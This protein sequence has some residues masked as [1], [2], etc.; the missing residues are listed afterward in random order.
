MDE[1][2]RGEVA[3]WLTKARRDL[4]SAYRLVAD[5]P[6]YRDTATYHCQQAAEKAL[7]ALLT[8]DETNFPKTHDLTVLLALAATKHADLAALADAAIVLTPYATLFR[9]PSAVVEP[10]DAD[11]KEALSL[12]RQVLEAVELQLGLTGQTST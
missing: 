1:V 12:A 5:F 4:D 3:A 9:Y 7:K 6:P 11:V 8:A 2:T 10:D